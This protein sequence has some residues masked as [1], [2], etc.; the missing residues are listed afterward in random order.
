VLEASRAE[1]DQ[2]LG[3][4]QKLHE[5]SWGIIRTLL[6]DSQ[7]KASR[8]VDACLER[9]E[10]EIQQRVNSEISMT[11]QNLDIEAGARLAAR[12]DQA[13]ATA[14]ERQ[15][16]IEQDLAKS[17]TENRQQLN[18]LSSEAA[19]AVQQREQSLLEGLKKEAEEQL[20]ALEKKAHQ[21][22][23]TVQNLGNSLGNELKQR[24]DEA[25]NTFQSRVD[26]LWQEIVQRVERRIGET[27]A[28][29]TAE[30]A[31]DARQVVDREMSDFLTQA[32]R[33]FDRSAGDQSS[34]NS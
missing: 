24:T 16:S 9:F 27:A 14:K 12:L 34:R 7:V 25:F 2:L 15:Q 32:L 13:L 3:E 26:E 28:T 1:L 6:E 8:A 21:I 33:R 22:I 30:M 19:Q 20:S 4:T 23:D 10:A 31:K 17:V 18:Q 5:R 11:L 29:C